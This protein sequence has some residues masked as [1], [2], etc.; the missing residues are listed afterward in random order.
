[1]LARF[2][3]VLAAAA[4]MGAMLP[5]GTT[6]LQASAGGNPPAQVASS[7]PSST[8]IDI[9]HK[10]MKSVLDGHAVA[11]VV[12]ARTGSEI[13]V[14][15]LFVKNSSVEMFQLASDAVIWRGGWQFVGQAHLRN[16]PVDLVVSNHEVLGVLAYHDAYGRVLH[17]K[18]NWVTIQAVRGRSGSNPACRVGFGQPF[19]ARING[20][21]VWNSKRYLLPRHSLVQ[22]TVYGVPGYPFML[23]GVEDYGRAP[24][25]ASAHP[26]SNAAIFWPDITR[27][28][29][30]LG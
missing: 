24:C 9:G 6:L 1:M 18:G 30:V 20:G 10:V 11:G 14:Q 28:A 29:N 17:R 25:H 15:P 5:S 21:T 12:L 8:A 2:L 7:Q 13:W 27:Q 3:A 4:G 23:G 16:L 26:H 22:Y 19:R